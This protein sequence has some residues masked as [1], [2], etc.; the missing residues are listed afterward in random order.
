MGGGAPPHPGALTV[1]TDQD[2]VHVAGAV[3]PDEEGHLSM[4]PDRLGPVCKQTL[5]GNP[6]APPSAYFSMA[7]GTVRRIFSTG[8]TAT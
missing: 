1:L 6:A 3:H 5:A 4:S 2:D 7:S 8:T